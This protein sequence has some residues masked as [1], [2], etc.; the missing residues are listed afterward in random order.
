M[1][2]KDCNTAIRESLDIESL[3]L[4]IERSQL[5]YLGHLS[6]MPW[7]R[8]PKQ[9]SYAEVSRKRPVGRPQTRWLNYIEDLRCL[10]LHPSE[11][12][13]VLVDREVRGLNLRQLPP[14]PFRKS[15]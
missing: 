2:D 6:R 10:G 5:R 3:H 1:F 13:S 9:T 14:Q 15:G 11:M 7:D 8:L 12:Q 4:Q